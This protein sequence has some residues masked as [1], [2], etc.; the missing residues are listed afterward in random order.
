MPIGRTRSRTTM[1]TRTRR[2][3]ASPDERTTILTPTAGIRR[4]GTRTG[5][6]FATAKKGCGRPRGNAEVHTESLLG[7][8]EI[9]AK[10]LPGSYWEVTWPQ[11]ASTWPRPAS[12]EKIDISR[13]NF[14]AER[15]LPEKRWQRWQKLRKSTVR[16]TSRAR[17]FRFEWETGGRRETSII[18]VATGNF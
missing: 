2:Q 1:M 12:A 18:T 3:N 5:A 14:R 7:C 8:Y 11:A 10:C 13:P 9:F 4:I 6:L 16:E 17:H 15:C